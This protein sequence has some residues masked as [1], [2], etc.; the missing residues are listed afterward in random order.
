[1][2][3]SFASNTPSKRSVVSA[4]LAAL[5][6]VLAIPVQADDAYPSRPVIMVV[7][8]AAGGASDVIARLVADQMSA[9]LG[10]RVII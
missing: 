5:I 10:Q 9:S 7:P 8:F 6:S 3:L 4:L 1:M 2:T